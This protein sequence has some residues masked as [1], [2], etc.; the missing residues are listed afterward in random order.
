MFHLVLSE[1]CSG[2]SVVTKWW[3]DIARWNMKKVVVVVVIRM[4]GSGSRW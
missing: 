1:W 3:S 4:S 2:R